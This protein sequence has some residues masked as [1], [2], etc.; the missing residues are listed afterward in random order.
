MPLFEY[1]NNNFWTNHEIRDQF[2]QVQEWTPRI[3]DV[4]EVSDDYIKR[5]YEA[6]KNHDYNT[7]A[8]IQDEFVAPNKDAGTRGREMNRNVNRMEYD[9]TQ[10]SIHGNAPDVLK[11]ADDKVALTVDKILNAFKTHGY[12]LNSCASAVGSEPIVTQDYEGQLKM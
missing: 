1:S 7:L 12:T 9:P 10:P 2:S 8:K 5:A 4:G 6:Y 3:G 11:Q